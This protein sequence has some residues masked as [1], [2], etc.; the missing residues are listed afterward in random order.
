[1]I[2]LDET[3][4]VK[5]DISF[6]SNKLESSGLKKRYKDSLEVIQDLTKEIEA[7][8]AIRQSEDIYTI[9]DEGDKSS[10]SEATAIILA[11]DWHIEEL[12]DPKTINGL[13]KFNL[14]IAEGRANRFF[15]NSTK[16][17]KG[18]QR[19]IKIKNIVLW[20]GGDFISSNIHEELLENTCLRPIDAIKKAQA[21]ILA[22]INY[23]LNETNCNIIIPCNSGNHARI[24]K[25]IHISGEEGNSLENYMYCNLASLFSGEKR[26]QFV[27]GAGSQIYLNIYKYKL[28]FLHGTHIRY[29]GGVG[30]L[31]IPAN[32]AI[33]SWNR[34]I[35][36]DYTM[37]GHLHTRLDGGVFLANGSL[38]GYNAYA[39]SIKASFEEPS[40]TFFLLDKLRGKSIV[41]PIFMR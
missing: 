15:A 40:Q 18:F 2:E 13:N 14:K 31:T 12:V 30:G 38:I 22:G 5:K 7:I 36:A 11:S 37:F 6:L 39:L 3:S 23:I 34:A 41:A 17:V 1:M 32:K 25:K 19:D 27:V 8:Q 28:R 10:Q 9:V 26:V 20:L 16:L 29:Q 21:I 33:A 24:T 35:K 4:E